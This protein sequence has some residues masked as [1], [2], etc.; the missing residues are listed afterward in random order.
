MMRRMA[1]HTPPLASVRV[2]WIQQVSALHRVSRRTTRPRD[3]AL[4]A[5]DGY[6][7]SPVSQHPQPQ[8]DDVCNARCLGSQDQTSSSPS[9]SAVASS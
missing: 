2:R 6:G 3:A 9:P 8:A 7:R 5:V 4:G 1:N